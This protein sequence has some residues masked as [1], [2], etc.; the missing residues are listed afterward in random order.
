MRAAGLASVSGGVQSIM[1]IA[2]LAVEMVSMSDSPSAMFSLRIAP[3]PRSSTWALWSGPRSKLDGLIRPWAMPAAW[4]AA[5]PWSASATNRTA[6][7]GA[8]GPVRR[9]RLSNVS[10]STNGQTR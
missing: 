5:N 1:L 7:A 6:C 10:P 4:H 9:T 8:S 2:T 3:M